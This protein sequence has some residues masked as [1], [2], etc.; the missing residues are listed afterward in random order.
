[1]RAHETPTMPM[2]AV[3]AAMERTKRVLN[4]Q[5]ANMKCAMSHALLSV[6]P[7]M[8]RASRKRDRRVE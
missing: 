1:M 2:R 8:T 3:A 5:P 4:M 7:G 6:R